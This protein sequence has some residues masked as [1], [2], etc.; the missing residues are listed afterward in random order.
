MAKVF[1]EYRPRLGAAH[2]YISAKGSQIGSPK[3]VCSIEESTNSI[4]IV[5]KS[6]DGIDKEFGKFLWPDQFGKLCLNETGI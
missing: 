6:E 2:V 3:Y 1:I 4:V 5:E